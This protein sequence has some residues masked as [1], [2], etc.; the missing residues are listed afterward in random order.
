MTD[1]V[2]PPPPGSMYLFDYVTPPLAPNKYRIEERTDV[3][4]DG[5]AH[6]LP[7]ARY[8][9]VVGPRFAMPPQDVAG[10][11]PPRNGHGPF[12]DSLAQIAIKHRTLPWERK[13]DKNNVIG[14]PTGGNLLAADYPVPWVALLLFEEG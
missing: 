7:E 14:N 6:A 8:F 3:A 10:V 1:P 11:F 4:F 13:L 2:P 5:Q 12:Q 9:E